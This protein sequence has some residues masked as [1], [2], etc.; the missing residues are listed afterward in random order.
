[1][2]GRKI[3]FRPFFLQ[4]PIMSQPTCIVDFGRAG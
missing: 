2:S 3:T 1:M 4:R